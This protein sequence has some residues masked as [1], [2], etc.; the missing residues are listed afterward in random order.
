MHVFSPLK[1]KH[2][3]FYNRSL[4]IYLQFLVENEIVINVFCFFFIFYVKVAAQPMTKRKGK[5]ALGVRCDFIGSSTNVVWFQ[6]LYLDPIPM[7]LFILR[8]WI[9]GEFDECTTMILTKVT[10]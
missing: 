1:W 8:V 9:D 5:G 4:I 6:E 3:N 2:L 10:L 7:F